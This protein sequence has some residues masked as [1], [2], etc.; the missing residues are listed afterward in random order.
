MKR[1]ASG[2]RPGPSAPDNMLYGLLPKYQE[3]LA[4]PGATVHGPRKLH[5]LRILH[6]RVW[7]WKWRVRGAHTS[8]ISACGVVRT[9]LTILRGDHARNALL[10]GNNEGCGLQAIAA[11]ASALAAVR[12]LLCGSTRR[13]LGQIAGV[14]IIAIHNGCLRRAETR[15]FVP[16]EARARACRTAAPRGHHTLCLPLE[17][18][19]SVAPGCMYI[20]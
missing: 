9:A 14:A 12:G 17:V 18:L 2:R 5:R 4:L 7:P 3:P 19:T 6:A 13:N 1:S 8:P 11:P 16:H 20:T 10:H 15:V